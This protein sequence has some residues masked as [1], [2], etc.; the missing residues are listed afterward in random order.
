VYYRDSA[1][2]KWIRLSAAAKQLTSGNIGGTRDDLAGVWSD[3]LWVRYSADGSWKK[4]D[5]GIPIWITVGDITGDKR[6]DIVG[7]YGTGT[8]CRNSAT[9]GWTQLASPAAQLAAGDLDGDGRDDLVGIWSN[10]VYVRYGATGKWQQ[11]STSKPKWIATGKMTEAVQA[12]GALDDPSES[13]VDLLDLSE[14]GPGG[15]YDPAVSSEADGP[16]IP[17]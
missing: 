12:A 14:E 13:A 15:W 1:T 16:M 2:G 7:S 3:G 8:W 10:T 4:L 17:E 5:S 6:A 9:G 11:I